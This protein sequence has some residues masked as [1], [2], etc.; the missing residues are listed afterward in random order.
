MAAVE[1][2]LE[3]FGYVVLKEHLETCGGGK[4]SARGNNKWVDEA[5]ELMKKLK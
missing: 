4:T 3:A 1:R 5:F 2:A